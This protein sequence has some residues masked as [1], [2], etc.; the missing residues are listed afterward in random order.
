M[1]HKGQA[2]VLVILLIPIIFLLLFGTIETIS[3]TYQKN[4]VTSNIKTIIN[5][6]YDDC[7][8][9][10]IRELFKKNNIIYDNLDIKRD[11]DLELS[12][13]VKISGFI[14]DNYLIDYRFV[15]TEEEDKINIKRV[16]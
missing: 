13:K 5:N 10:Q 7:T 6:C 1:N 8:D 15:G 4:K 14:K 11:N 12:I 16:S 3:V 2:L 9:E